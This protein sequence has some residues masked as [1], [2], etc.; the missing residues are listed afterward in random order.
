VGL[1]THGVPTKGFEGE[2]LHLRLL[3]RASWRNGSQV[4]RAIQSF[5]EWSPNPSTEDAVKFQTFT[6]NVQEA[7][8]RLL[9][10]D[11]G[12]KLREASVSVLT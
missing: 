6:Q 8:N 11:Y 4:N 3:F 2:S 5:L 9:S 12:G 1:V 10:G 7:L